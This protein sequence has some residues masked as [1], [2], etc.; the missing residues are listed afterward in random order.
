MR[1]SKWLLILSRVSYVM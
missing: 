1:G